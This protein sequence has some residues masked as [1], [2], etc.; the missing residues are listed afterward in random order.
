M[1]N[2]MK[3]TPAR[4]LAAGAALA[5]AGC[6]TPQAA[7][8]GKAAAAKP[9]MWRVADEDTTIYLFGTFHLLPP[10]HVW[11]TA[12]LDQALAQADELVLEIAASDDAAAMAAPLMKLG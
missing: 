2:W 4:L 12:A 8:S 3:R 9:A 10:G 5:L 6:T 7:E 11:R 1:L